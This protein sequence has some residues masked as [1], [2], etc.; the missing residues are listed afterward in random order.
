MPKLSNLNLTPEKL[1]SLLDKGLSLR[2]IAKQYDVSA[3]TISRLLKKFNIQIKA[4]YS[5][6][7]SHIDKAVQDS[8]NKIKKPKL[9]IDID[10]IIEAYGLSVK[11]LD[12]DNDLSAMLVKKTIYI[13]KNEYE[14]NPSRA[15]FSKA[16]ELGHFVLHNVE[17][18]EFKPV[19]F[20]SLGIENEEKV[21]EREANQFSASLLMPEALLENAIAD[22]QELTEDDIR[23]LAKKF[24][25]SFT[26]M[27]IRLSSFGFLL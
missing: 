4:V 1:K 11:Y 23:D 27:S 13:N 16:H 3:M 10:A 26:A 21:R 19:R 17:A 7:L 5:P 24:N 15:N 6:D 8:L 2:D 20:R 14:K 22:K 25:V 12:F 9:P 18:H